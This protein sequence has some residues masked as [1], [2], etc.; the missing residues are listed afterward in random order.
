MWY[1]H[2]TACMRTHI[3]THTDTLEPG[4][5]RRHHVDARWGTLFSPHPPSPSLTPCP[6]SVLLLAGL[7]LDTFTFS[8][9]PISW[10]SLDFLPSHS[11]T[12]KFPDSPSFLSSETNAPCF[13]HL[14]LQSL[15]HLSPAL[16]SSLPFAPLLWPSLLYPQAEG[17]PHLLRVCASILVID[18]RV[19]EAVLFLRDLWL[20]SKEKQ[21]WC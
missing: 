6:S 16:A 14:F 21:P 2:H 19:A 13:Y 1:A 20:V 15:A 9:H 17:F 7:S 10:K 11:W 5:C 12:S 18:W 4:V 3:W 8:A